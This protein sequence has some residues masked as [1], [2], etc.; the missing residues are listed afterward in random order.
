[1]KV[2][3]AD[4]KE[5]ESVASRGAS[6]LSDSVVPPLKRGSERLGVGV[7]NEGRCPENAEVRNGPNLLEAIPGAWGSP[8]IPEVNDLA[9]MD[10]GTED[11]NVEFTY[12]KGNGLYVGRSEVTYFTISD[13]F[14]SAYGEG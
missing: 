6:S 13:L 8:P 1:M 9:E 4:P 7:V 10:R 3:E 12:D 14:V 5:V 11:G 2:N